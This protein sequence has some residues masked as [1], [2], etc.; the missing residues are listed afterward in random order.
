MDLLGRFKQKLR[1]LKTR[2]ETWL[3]TAKYVGVLAMFLIVFVPVYG[4]VST[5]STDV[6]TMESQLENMKKIG[7]SLL[8]QVDLK[9]LSERVE[10]FE[11]KLVDASRASELLDQISDEAEKNKFE[12]IQIYSDTPLP[13]KDAQEADVQIGAKKLSLLPVTFRVQTDAKS[14]ANFL[15]SLEENSSGVFV[16]ESLHLQ[17][18][19]VETQTLQGD[20]TLSFILG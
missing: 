3:W 10:R 15:R 11:A 14:F 6:Q 5:R 16:V 13:L 7:P 20:V 4:R 17:K 9:A 18:T 2:K 19:S 1:H 8:S 12:V